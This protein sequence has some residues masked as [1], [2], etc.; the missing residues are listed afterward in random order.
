MET[1]RSRR[2]PP[3]STQGGARHASP[4]RC[5]CTPTGSS[6]SRLS[7]IGEGGL[8]SLNVRLRERNGVI[9]RIDVCAQVAPFPEHDIELNVLLALR[10]FV[11][12]RFI[13]SPAVEELLLEVIPHV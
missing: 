7:R 11:L 1:A 8:A 4:P 6:R 9:Q 2:T 3:A 13:P 5:R 10:A 12:N